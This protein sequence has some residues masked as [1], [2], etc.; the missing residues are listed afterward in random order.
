MKKLV[1]IFTVSFLLLIAFSSISIAC[2]KGCTPG[3]WKQAQ[4]WDSWINHSTGDAFDDVFTC[5]DTGELTLLEALKK[6]GGGIYALRRHAVA[7]LLNCEAFPCFDGGSPLDAVED[8]CS[9]LDSAMS[10]ETQKDEFETNND[11]TCPLN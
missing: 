8:Y 3:Y 5:E 6:G 2:N 7:S 9:S 1:S 4:H 11:Q 10:I